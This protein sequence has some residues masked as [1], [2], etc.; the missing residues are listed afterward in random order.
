MLCLT[1]LTGITWISLQVLWGFGW[2][3]TGISND[4]DIH[5]CHCSYKTQKHH[6]TLHEDV[7]SLLPPFLVT[8]GRYQIVLLMSYSLNSCYWLSIGQKLER[9]HTKSKLH[10]CRWSF[11]YGYNSVKKKKKM[12]KSSKMLIDAEMY[13]KPQ[14]SWVSILTDAIVFYL[15]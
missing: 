2:A 10:S 11:I 15:L 7:C 14:T 1:R 12:L 13:Q 3:L 6:W 5:A 4:S 9:N 8:V